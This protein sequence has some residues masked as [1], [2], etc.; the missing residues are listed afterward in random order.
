MFSSRLDWTTKLNPI[1]QLLSEKRA[2]GAEILDLTQSNPTDAGIEY[3]L[4]LTAALADPSSVRYEPE[5]FGLPFAR[6]EAASYYCGAVDPSRIILTAST[7]EAYAY[8][9]KLLCN[10]GDEVLTPRPSYPLFEYL[11]KLESVR[12]KQYPLFYDHGWHVDTGAL[13]AA[14]TPRTRAIVT[15]H[16]NNPTGSFLKRNELAELTEIALEHELAIISDEV[17]SDYAIGPDPTRAGVVANESEALSFSL[18]GLSK[19]AGLPQMKL[20]WMVVGGRRDLRDAALHRLEL[21]A[22]TYLSIGT[23]VQIAAGELLRVRKFIQPQIL[24]RLRRNRAKLPVHLDVEGGWY[25]TVRAPRVMTE[26]EW[27]TH[28]LR[29]YDVLVQPGFFY[30][31]ESEAYLVISALTQPAIFDEGLLRLA[32]LLAKAA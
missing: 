23:P 17:F 14:I 28:L 32:S 1:A 8:L 9:F 21:I 6:Q 4:G 7:S 3:P 16:P 12:V 31:F 30:D 22:D 20:A 13:R 5:P 19:I 2:A 24:E 10:P 11:A 15:V 27:V 29:D 18:S 25:V 26:E